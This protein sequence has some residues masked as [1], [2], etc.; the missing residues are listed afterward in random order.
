MTRMKWN[1]AQPPEELIEEW[2]GISKCYSAVLFD[3]VTVVFVH[4]PLETKQ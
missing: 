3:T 2:I 4:C 1:E